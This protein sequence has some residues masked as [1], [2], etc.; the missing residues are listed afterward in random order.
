MTA[1]KR[2]YDASG[3]KGQPDFRCK[4]GGEFAFRVN[5]PSTATLTGV[6]AFNSCVTRGIHLDS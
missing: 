2:A 5:M 3:A 6:Q 1:Y 4:Q